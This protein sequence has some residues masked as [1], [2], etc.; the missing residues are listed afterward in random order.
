MFDSVTILFTD[1]CGFTS[2]CSHL[3]PMEVVNMLNQM[4]TKFDLICQKHKVYKV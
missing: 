4:Y 3:T 1:V 2:I